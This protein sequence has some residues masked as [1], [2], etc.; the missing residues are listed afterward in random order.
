MISQVE[1]VVDHYH[2]LPSGDWLLS[3]L[4]GL[5]T[6]LRIESIGCAVKLSEIYARVEFNPK[7]IESPNES[8]TS[9]EL[10]PMKRREI[11]SMGMIFSVILISVFA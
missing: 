3:T 10:T 6:T 11:G 8:T 9:D 4:E 5:G 1:P 2:K 7:Q